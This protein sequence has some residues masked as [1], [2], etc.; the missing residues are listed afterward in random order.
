[1]GVGRP[2][3]CEQ[4]R[5]S[6]SSPWGRDPQAARGAWAVAERAR[7][8]RGRGADVRRIGRPWRAESIVREPVAASHRDER[9]L[10]R[11]GCGPRSRVGPTPAS[12]IDRD[13]QRAK[14]EVPTA[15]SSPRERSAPVEIVG[16]LGGPPHCPAIGRGVAEALDPRPCYARRG[17]APA[18]CAPCGPDLV[19]H[20]DAIAAWGR[21][22][23][24][25]RAERRTPLDPSC[26]CPQITSINDGDA[27][28]VPNAHRYSRRCVGSRTL[29]S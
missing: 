7:R 22:Y 18:S 26:L 20:T 21:P 8:T 5:R 2:S 25:G 14:D 19:P 3:R 11:V 10:G 4:G 1:M 12:R 9:E 6:A 27:F 29:R 16:W 24:T 13:S 17:S 28:R 15:R 23:R